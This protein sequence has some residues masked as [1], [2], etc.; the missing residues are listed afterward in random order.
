MMC[1]WAMWRRVALRSTGS[2]CGVRLKEQGGE[3]GE[4]AEMLRE[5]GARLA[6]M[7]REGAAGAGTEKEFAR[8]RA[9]A[10]AV[11]ARPEFQARC[12]DVVGP[13]EGRMRVVQVA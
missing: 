6:E 11:L 5:A 8:E 9:V 2:G 1:G 10:N 3:G 4:R 12:G 13:R 7:A